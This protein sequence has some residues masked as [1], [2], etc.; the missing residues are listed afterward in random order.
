MIGTNITANSISAANDLTALFPRCVNIK[1]GC[2]T[3]A[4]VGGWAIV[5]WK[6]LSSAGTFLAFMGG[7]A[8]FLAPIAGIIASDFWLARRQ[9]FDVPAIYDPF[10]RY[11]YSAGINSHG[12]GCIPLCRGA[13]SAGSRVEHQ[14]KYRH[15]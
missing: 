2:I 14:C 9:N 3:A 13:K 15:Q 1:R 6:I 12:D 8:V 7:H 5:P 11:C 10:G 4:L